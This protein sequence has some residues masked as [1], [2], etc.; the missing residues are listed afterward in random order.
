LRY[1]KKKE[2][3]LKICVYKFYKEKK[4]KDAHSKSFYERKS[5]QTNHIYNIIKRAENG[6]TAKR[7][8]VSVRIA[9][10]MNKKSA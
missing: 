7:E 4:T 9:E 10:K 2:D 5:S 6:L 3:V 1:N 8:L